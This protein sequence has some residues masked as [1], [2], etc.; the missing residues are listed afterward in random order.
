M[1][2]I[3]IIDKKI[4]NKFN[5]DGKTYQSHVEKYKNKDV[6]KSSAIAW[7][8]LDKY[9][10]S[11]FNININDY[12]LK[13]SQNGK[14]FIDE[15]IFFNISHSKNMIAIIISNRPCAIDIECIKKNKDYSKIAKTILNLD[16]LKYRDDKEYIVSLWTKIE[17][18]SKLYDAPLLSCLKVRPKASSK[19]IKDSEGNYYIISKMT[20]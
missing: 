8:A 14:P 10:A 16:E 19:K 18:Y 13:Y 9:L 3:Y 7:S 2:K 6:F 15:D 20:N 5:I 17:C 1:E 12:T 4:D 11:D